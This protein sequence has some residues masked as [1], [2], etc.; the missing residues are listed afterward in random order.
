MAQDLPDLPIGML[1]DVHLRRGLFALR[2]LLFTYLAVYH[3]LI[4][5]GRRGSAT[6]VDPRC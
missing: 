3:G 4:E 5:F 6:S 1:T 2:I